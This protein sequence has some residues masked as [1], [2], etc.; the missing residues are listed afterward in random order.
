M[1]KARKIMALLLVCMMVMLTACEGAENSSSGGVSGSPEET[2][3]SGTDTVPLGAGGEGRYVETDVT[4]EGEEIAGMFQLSDGTVALLTEGLTARYDSNDGGKTFTKSDWPGVQEGSLQNL[5]KISMA[6]DGTIYAVNSETPGGV[7][8]LVRITAE[9]AVESVPIEA[10]ESMKTA[11]KKPYIHALQVLSAEKVLIG[12]IDSTGMVT[13]PE[14]EADDSAEE[15]TASGEEEEGGSYSFASEQENIIAVFD[16]N[17][18][19]EIYDLQNA[20]GFMSTAVYADE[21]YL[22]DYNENI[23]VRNIET[24][25]ETRKIEGNQAAGGDFYFSM[26]LS[27]VSPNGQIYTQDNKGVYMRDAETGAKTQMF[28]SGAFSFVRAST[29]IISFSALSDGS[30]MMLVAGPDG[31]KV[32]RYA[33]DENAVTDPDK[34]LEVWSLEDNSTL[35]AAISDF[36]SDNPDATID[37]TIGKDEAGAQETE[38]IIKNLNTRIIAGDGPDILLLDGLPAK[39]Y[40]EKGMLMDLKPLIDFGNAYEEIL[41]TVES[42]GKLDYFPARFKTPLLLTSAAQLSSFSDLESMVKAIENGKDRPAQSADSGDPFSALSEEERPVFDFTDFDEMFESTHHSSVGRIIENGSFNAEAAK[43]F[44]DAMKRISDKYKLVELG[45][46]SSSASMVVVSSGSGGEAIS[47]NVISY[48]MDRALAGSFLL[49]NLSSLSAFADEDTV[50]SVMPGLTEGGYIPS[51]MMGISAGTDKAEFATD[52]LQ[53]ML[54]AD[55]QGV[56]GDGFP[57]TQEGF[58]IQLE[59]ASK[60]KGAGTELRKVDFDI[61]SILSIVKMPVITDK[62]VLDALKEAARA[63]CGGELSLDE[64]VGQIEENTRLYLAEQA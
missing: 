63:Y 32:Y 49:G 12:V 50:H 31:S 33:Y 36:L 23:S 18:G 5:G 10:V 7:E 54:S 53:N 64:A 46:S 2:I 43:T 44:L 40:A 51:T 1:K 37:L 52:F 29:L 57:I 62:V 13:A 28:E 35:R 27:D 15:D 22:Y 11:G 20:M 19:E 14:E 47:G 42:D 24:G 9:G 4:P 25:E 59:E 17:T 6:D 58:D 60:T 48:M 34:V 41:S 56:S 55:V 38:D 30:F 26:S 16:T 45:D 3:N 39:S 21:L 61:Q 8:E